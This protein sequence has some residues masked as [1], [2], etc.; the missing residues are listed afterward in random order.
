MPI[1]DIQATQPPSFQQ[2]NSRGLNVSSLIDAY[3]AQPLEF[4]R[5]RPGSSAFSA[6]SLVLSE[7]RVEGGAEKIAV[8][9]HRAARVAAS[10]REKSV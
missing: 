5:P 10:C 1:A 6:C 8:D 4:A 9:P 2:R 7:D 3:L